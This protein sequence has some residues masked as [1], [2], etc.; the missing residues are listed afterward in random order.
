MPGVSSP[1]WSAQ[2]STHGPTAQRR[3]GIEPGSLFEA[4]HR[5][6]RTSAD[7]RVQ[8]QAERT[9]SGVV[10]TDVALVASGAAVALRRRR[11]PQAGG[12]CG[13]AASKA[14]GTQEAPSSGRDEAAR[15]AAASRE[16]GRGAPLRAGQALADVGAAAALDAGLGRRPMMT[17]PAPSRPPP[18]Q[19]QAAGWAGE[20]WPGP[21]PFEVEEADAVVTDPGRTAPLSSS[22]PRSPAEWRI[23]LAHGERSG[24]R[25]KPRYPPVILVAGLGA[26][27]ANFTSGHFLAGH[28]RTASTRCCTYGTTGSV[29]D[30]GVASKASLKGEAC[31]S[32]IAGRW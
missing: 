25:P 3:P 11:R 20:G 31:G 5:L 22:A 15:S 4:N 23:H 29:L 1:W 17:P 12:V 32:G 2:T 13:K 27:I 26:R 14:D 9:A 18:G 24:R 10:V 6:Y 19:D 28:V 30:K 16:G 7:V 21:P 8:V